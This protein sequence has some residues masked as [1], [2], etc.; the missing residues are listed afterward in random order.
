[1]RLTL[2]AAVSLAGALAIP[3][4]ASAGTRT[5]H[6]AAPLR[7]DL[8]VEQLSVSSRTKPVLKLADAVHGVAAYGSAIPAGPGRWMVRVVA[9]RTR[10][11]ATSV[12]LKLTASTVWK[13]TDVLH[14]ATIVS[15]SGFQRPTVV[16][17]GPVSVG[18]T[19]LP[20]VSGP[21]PLPSPSTSPAAL[22]NRTGAFLTKNAINLSH[23]TVAAGS[24]QIVGVDRGM[25]PHQLA[26]RDSGGHVLAA[27]GDIAVG[28]EV[29][30]TATL[31][32]GMSAVLTV[33]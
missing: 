31:A 16:V 9:I 7:R 10:T 2:V 27:T 26:V 12:S 24:V 23:P 20:P 19:F 17:R 25:D 32:M 30:L 33:Q 28:A 22:P 14:H 29:N 18:A 6:I 21:T 1:V 15:P 5:P 13:A 11:A 8:T 4:H 3:A